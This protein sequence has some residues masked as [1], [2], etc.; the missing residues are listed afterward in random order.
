MRAKWK[1]GCRRSADRDGGRG[2]KAVSTM[3]R[4][5]QTPRL[6]LA[7]VRETDRDSLIALERDSEV[8]RYLNG[9]Y[10]APDGGETEGAGFLTPRGGEDYIWAAREIR[11][12]AFVG[13]FSLRP[14][15][16]GAAELG[17][18]LRRD[19]WGKGFASEGASALVAMGF[20][21]MGLERIV[22]TAMTVH[23][24]SRRVLE[25]AGLAY[26]RT[27]YPDW[28]ESFPGSELG[29]VEYTITRE[30]WERS[31]RSVRGMR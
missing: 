25:K 3:R 31:D 22:A 24:A 18:R 21:E 23:A 5:F 15:P 19:A 11:S 6:S 29:D 26:A 13:W 16:A 8:M 17:Y 28:P 10:A 7:L 30:K 12:G 27:V 2:D 14:A 20:A 9:G 4:S 1:A